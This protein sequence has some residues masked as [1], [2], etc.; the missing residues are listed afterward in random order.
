MTDPVSQPHYAYVKALLLY[1]EPSDFRPDHYREIRK[2]KNL[3][4]S[5]NFETRSYGIS[6]DDNPQVVYDIVEDEH[7][8]ITHKTR[9]LGASCLLIIYYAEDTDN[10]YSKQY[11]EPGWAQTLLAFWRP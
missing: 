4:E 9:A 3:F 8:T 2:L 5:L 1:D 10:D 6:T 11:A 7:I